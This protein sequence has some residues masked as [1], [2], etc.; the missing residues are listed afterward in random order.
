MKIVINDGLKI[1][2]HNKN[3]GQATYSRHIR[4]NSRASKAKTKKKTNI[5]KGTLKIATRG[6]QQLC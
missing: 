4:G 6:E 5:G 3:Y 2:G 1:E